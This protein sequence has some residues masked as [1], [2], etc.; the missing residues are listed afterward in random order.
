V[1]GF[2]VEPVVTADRQVVFVTNR[3][4]VQSPWIVPLAGGDATEIVRE[5]AVSRNTDV[6]PDGRRLAFYSA[7]TRGIVV[8]DLPRCENRLE[9]PAP[10][11][12]AETLRWTADGNGLGY[13]VAPLTDIWVMPLDGG[14]PRAVTSFGPDASAIAS[15]AWSRDGRRLAFVRT[16]TEYSVVMLSG[17]RP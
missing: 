17:L 6:S 5:V 9:L 13:L 1:S 11:N 8:C 7:R 3:S 12:Y 15:F 2:A 16:R 4:G 10:T 14:A